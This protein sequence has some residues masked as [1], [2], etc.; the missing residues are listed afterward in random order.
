MPAS[1]HRDDV[2]DARR[3]RIR[4]LDIEV[5]ALPADAADLLRGEDL[6]LVALEL[7][8][9]RAVVVGAG[10]GF[11]GSG[12]CAVWHGGLLSGHEKCTVYGV[13][14]CVHLLLVLY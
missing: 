12:S 11:V 3:H 13:R 14:Q 2:V 9:L 7:C 10:V 1:A 6:A 8:P 4:P 5:H